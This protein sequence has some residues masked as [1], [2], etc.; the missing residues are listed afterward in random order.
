MSAARR[1]AEGCDREIVVLRDDARGSCGVGLGDRLDVK[2]AQCVAALAERLSVAHNTLDRVERGARFRHQL[3]MDTQEMFAGDEE[4]GV[5]QQMMDVG[6]AAGVRVFDRDHGAADFARLYGGE[7]VFERRIG[8]GFEIRK[9]FGAGQMRI[10]SGL[11]LVGDPLQRRRVL[12]VG[13]AFG[14]GR[15]LRCQVEAGEINC[16]ARSRSA[17]VSTPSGTV[18]TIDTSMRHAVFQRA[19]LSSFSRRSR[20]ESGRATKRSS[21]ARR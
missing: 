21:A 4:I 7:R 9:G 20:P 11:A 18:S 15:C 14:L 6:D 13:I 3:V 10:G 12:D 2:L 8:N 1:E 16:R 17:G 5:R 19:Q